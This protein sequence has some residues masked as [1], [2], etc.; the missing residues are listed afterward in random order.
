[1]GARGRSV[2]VGLLVVAMVAL[3]V[4][5]S[6]PWFRAGTTDWTGTE[7]TSGLVGSW[8]WLLLVLLVLLLVVS[9]TGRRAVGVLMALVGVG[10]VSTSLLQGSP[11][12]DELLRAGVREATSTGASWIAVAGGF[13]AVLGGALVALT[14]ATWPTR[15]RPSARGVPDEVDL[16][17]AQDTGLDPTVG[18]GSQ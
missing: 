17:R 1:M 4:S 10:A 18:D 8:A 7:L 14:A 9:T 3:Q 6:R 16:W 15:R 12:A 13:A 5:A 11:A 2:A